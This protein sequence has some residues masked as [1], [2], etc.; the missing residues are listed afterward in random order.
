V[1]PE[2]KKLVLLGQIAALAGA[3][4]LSAA[5]PEFDFTTAAGVEGW[6]AQHDLSA[7]VA[8]PEGLRA[9]INGPDPYFA[10]PPRDYPSGQPLWMRLWLHSETSGVLQV[11]YFPA[12]GSPAEAHSVQTTVPA[13]EWVQVR[14]R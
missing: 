4:Q 9:D 6:T 1:F 5:L 2:M 13:G 8:T 12:S 14:R 3:C 10:G 7:L 11:F